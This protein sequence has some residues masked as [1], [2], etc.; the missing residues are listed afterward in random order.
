MGAR[1]LRGTRP[2]LL[3]GVA[4]M[5]IQHAKRPVVVVPAP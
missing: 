2:P 3:G 1:G 4:R 5:T